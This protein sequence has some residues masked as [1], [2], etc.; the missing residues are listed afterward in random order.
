PQ[1]LARLNSNGTLDSTF[2]S[3]GQVNATIMASGVALQP[4]GKIIIAGSDPY[5]TSGPVYE[6]AR[7]NPDG[8][9]D[10]TF[11]SNGIATVMVAPAA[12]VVQGDGNILAVGRPADAYSTP[13]F[14][15]LRL[16]SSGAV[17]TTFGTS[18]Q[19]A[20]SFTGTVDSI[21]TSDA[22]QTDG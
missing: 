19:V 2:G 8:S 17:D 16:G 15:L 18:G 7:Y 9:V 3:N 14:V 6:V 21:A 12:I 1:F 22:V 11:S 20:T 13:M 4:D 10:T 5:S